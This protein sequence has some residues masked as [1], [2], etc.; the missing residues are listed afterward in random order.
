MKTVTR[1]RTPQQTA[2]RVI[3]V[4]HATPK[5]VAPLK[6]DASDE[7]RMKHLLKTISENVDA[8]A[9]ANARTEAAKESLFGLMK[10]YR[11]PKYEAEALVATIT[12]S[13]GRSVSTIDV[14]GF[15]K[16]VS[17]EDF[18]SCVK[19]SVKEAKT[20]LAGKELDSVTETTPAKLGDEYLEISSA[21]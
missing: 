9:K 11:L 17:D 2:A 15:K 1:T 13:P 3:R 19:V 4:R 21:K 5:V 6:V 16:L 14:H 20:V 8:V 7:R 12:R 10:T 18:M